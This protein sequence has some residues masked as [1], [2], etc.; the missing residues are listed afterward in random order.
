MID[1][2]TAVSRVL[3]EAVA[4]AGQRDEVFRPVLLPVETG[5]GPSITLG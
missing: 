1:N 3:V 2:F 5:E 4:S